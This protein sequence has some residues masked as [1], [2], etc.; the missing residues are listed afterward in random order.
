MIYKCVSCLLTIGKKIDNVKLPYNIKLLVSRSPVQHKKKVVS[1]S[2][3]RIYFL[4][5][6]KSMSNVRSFGDGRKLNGSQDTDLRQ[7]ALNCLALY[8]L[9]SGASK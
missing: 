6:I 3:K 9:F 8:T 4:H 1:D 7:K 5:F 2:P